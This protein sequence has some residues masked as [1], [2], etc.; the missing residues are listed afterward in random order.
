M[1]NGH[2]KKNA[3]V[4]DLMK[5]S[6]PSDPGLPLRLRF[7]IQSQGFQPDT[8]D[9]HGLLILVQSGSSTFLHQAHS[10]VL[11]FRTFQKRR[12]EPV[13]SS[14]RVQSVELVGGEAEAEERRGKGKKHRFSRSFLRPA[15]AMF[16]GAVSEMV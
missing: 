3:E 12:R 9:I 8:I 14:S 1:S 7:G 2:V 15:E 13:S 5:Q 6:E 11:L 4:L 10:H 16:C